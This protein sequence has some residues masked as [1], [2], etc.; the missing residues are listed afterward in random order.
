MNT[1]LTD[2]G[3]ATRVTQ[4]NNTHTGVDSIGGFKI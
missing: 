2:L 3:L 1:T 4:T